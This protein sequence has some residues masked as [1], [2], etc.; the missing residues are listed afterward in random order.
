MTLIFRLASALCIVLA[1]TAPHAQ[2]AATPSPTTTVAAAEP[3]EKGLSPVGVEQA[4]AATSP[5]VTTKP[6]GATVALSPATTAASPDPAP[7][8]GLGR[9]DLEHI[10]QASEKRISDRIAAS[11]PSIW[12]ILLPALIGV[13]GALLG[14]AAGGLAAYLTQRSRI[15]YDLKAAQR[16]VAHQ[17]QADRMAFR[18]RQL[19]EFYGPMR[20]RLKQSLELRQELYAQLE[21][22]ATDDVAVFYKPDS[23][24][25]I[26]KSLWLQV[27]GKEPRPFRLIEEL[28]LLVSRFPELIPHVSEIVGI[29]DHI[30]A[31]IHEQIGLVRSSS[32]DLNDMLAKYLAHRSVM[33]EAF[34]RATTKSELPPLSGYAAVFPR[35]LDRI[36]ER[37]F[38]WLRQE[39]SGW[40]ASVL[41]WLADAGVTLLVDKNK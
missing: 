30:A 13:A 1:G 23:E 9:N 28:P 34:E 24:A 40:E 17:A 3:P 5:N 20:A 36:I 37:D 6:T 38:S 25:S 26:G 11:A 31:L 22:H 18:A 14:A 12:S 16:Q 8:R 33:R 7:D 21:R 29:S 35:G 4:N 39:L 10:V 41:A 32:D 27:D 19:H 2:P 15:A